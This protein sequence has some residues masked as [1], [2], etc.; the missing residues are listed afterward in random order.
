MEFHYLLIATVSFVLSFIF[1]LGG[2]GGAIVLVPVL[3]MLGV[4]FNYA[5]PAGLFTNLISGTAIVLN[6]LKN[7]RIDW[8]LALPLM[9]SSVIM[10]PVGVYA[11]H[12]VPQKVV[13]AILSAFLIYAGIMVYIPKKA[14]HIREDYPLWL[15]FVVGG[16][17]GFFSGMLG[18]G[19]GSLASPILMVLGLNPRKIISSVALMV[20]FSSLAGF[21]AYWKIGSVDWKV[22]LAAALPAF[23]AGYLGTHVAHNHL[24]MTKIKKIL[25][26]I[27]LLVGIK[28]F[29]K[30]F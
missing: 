1:A 21:L 7:R 23:I 14:E 4:P 29:L 18:V 2:I 10:A 24:S 30:W 20:F 25:G 27:Y 15:P 12:I 13:A 8:Q 3:T 16:I 19:G 6:N 5:R 26:V 22:T 17:T 11:S 9:V 28:F